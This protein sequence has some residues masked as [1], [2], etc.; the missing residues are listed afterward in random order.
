MSFENEDALATIHPLTIDF[1]VYYTMLLPE[2]AHE[3]PPALVLA[4]HGYGQKCRG[5]LRQFTALRNRNL[6]LV[7]PQGPHQIYMQ[8]EPKKVGFNWLTIYQKE[9]SIRDFIGY[10]N[11]LVHAVSEQHRFDPDRIFVLGFSQGVSMAYRLLAS[12]ILPV[13][14][15][16][17]CCSDLPPDVVEALPAIEPVPVLLAHSPD[18]PV[19]PPEKGDEAERILS[20]YQFPVTRVEYAGGHVITPEVCELVGDWLAECIGN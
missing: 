8:M 10:M 1:T 19:A 3:Q 20:T 4:L 15:V 9:N 16:V 11:R 2:T 5:F 7:A 12:G 6:L 17:A 14:G 18:D 13:A